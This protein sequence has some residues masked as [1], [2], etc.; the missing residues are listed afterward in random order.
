LISEAVRGEG[1]FLVDRDGHRFMKDFHPDGELAPRD[2]V[3]Q[4]IHHH[5]QETR[6]NC[7]FLDVRHIGHFQKR[8]PH[9]TELC[10]QF[11]ID[12]ARNL[13]PV[14]PSAHYMIGG[15][16]TGLD[17][18]TSLP[19]LLCCGE[20]S[21]SGVH[22]AN[23]LASNSLLEGLVF[24]QVAGQTARESVRSADRQR[25]VQHVS[26]SNPESG[27]TAMDLP[28]I[29]SSLRSVTWRNVGVVRTA[30]RLRETAHIL[31]FWA[32]YTL[33][34]TFQ[35]SAGWEVQNQLT[36]AHLIVR[37]A[38]ARADSIGV[39]YRSDSTGSPAA[40]YH[41]T[42]TRGESGSN[43]KRCPVQAESQEVRTNHAP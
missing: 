11:R 14:R 9:I 33:D 18:T 13:I 30:D 43:P 32:H 29:S 17:A 42:M 1:A 2:V 20:A 3:S 26:H 19:G 5:L 22:G 23:R 10:K 25:A 12:P 15:V 27:R 8:F 41:L 40:P 16:Q 39:H 34:K 37:A 21:S 7:V 28:D 24:G 35:D 38:L 36:V 4:A 31:D 6:S